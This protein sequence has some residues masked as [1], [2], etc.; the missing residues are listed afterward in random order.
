MENGHTVPTV[1]TLEKMARTLE[2][3]MYRLFYDGEAPPKLESLPERKTPD[4]IAWGSSSNGA[5]Y[6]SNS[7]RLL[8]HI[9]EK[10]RKPLLALL[11]NW[12]LDDGLRGFDI[13][14]NMIWRVLSCQMLSVFEFAETSQFSK[15]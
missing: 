3:S 5:W 4:G 7:R 11:A 9:E 8:G 2:V 10:G 14:V 13:L 12:R 6:V 15:S 1:E